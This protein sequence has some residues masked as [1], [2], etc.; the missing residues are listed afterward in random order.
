MASETE[1]SDKKDNTSGDSGVC[2]SCMGQ[3]L[4]GR[5]VVTGQDMHKLDEAASK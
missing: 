2:I 4:R 3:R 1:G 5:G